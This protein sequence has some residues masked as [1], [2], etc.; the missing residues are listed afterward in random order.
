MGSTYFI[1]YYCKFYCNCNTSDFKLLLFYYNNDISY[2]RVVLFNYMILSS[3]FRVWFSYYMI[4]ISAFI[5][6]IGIDI[7]TSLS[8]LELDN[9][10]VIYI[11]DLG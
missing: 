3:D 5:L 11:A 9:A 8:Y 4:Y 1:A 10:W 2:F 6:F 7:L